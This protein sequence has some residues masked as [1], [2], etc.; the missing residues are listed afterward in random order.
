MRR[1]ALST[2]VI[3]AVIGV[4]ALAVAPSASAAGYTNPFRIMNTSWCLDG[5][6][7]H[8]G[9]EVYSTGCNGG[10]F[11]NWHW[12]N[13]HNSLMQ[14]QA[15]GQGCMQQAGLRIDLVPCRSTVPLQRW[16][17]Y[18]PNYIKKTG[19]NLCITKFGV[20]NIDLETCGAGGGYQHWSSF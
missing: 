20:S 8:A 3:G 1:R 17:V 4:V 2:L 12:E 14:S 11:Q 10:A 6:N 5:Y 9:G 7:G 15:S 13:N 16:D 18:P 19:T